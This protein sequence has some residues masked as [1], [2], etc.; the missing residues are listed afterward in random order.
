MARHEAVDGGEEAAKSPIKGQFS[1]L[2]ANAANQTRKLRLTD[3]GR[4]EAVIVE[5]QTGDMLEVGVLA[6]GQTAAIADSTPTSILT[7]TALGGN[8][9][10][11]CIAVSGESA[12]D[13]TF[14]VNTVQEGVRRTTHDRLSENFIFGGNFILPENDILVIK[15]SHC[16]TGKN[17]I[18]EAT[19]YGV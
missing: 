7:F 4:M 1:I 13:F 5:D 6:K 9:K 16:A 10:I 19:V 2:G 17:K 15:V 18:F 8:K 14:E 3:D 11:S 12:A